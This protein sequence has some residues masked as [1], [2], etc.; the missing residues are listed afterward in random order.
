M[1]AL[2]GRRKLPPIRTPPP[3][4]PAKTGIRKGGEKTRNRPRR[5]PIFRE[6]EIPPKFGRKRLALIYIY[7]IFYIQV[8]EHRRQAR[9][10]EART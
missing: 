10:K 7:M 2:Q 9:P 6:S 8:N 3:A 1:N 5:P 4:I